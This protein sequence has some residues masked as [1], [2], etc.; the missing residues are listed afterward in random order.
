MIARPFH[1]SVLSASNDDQSENSNRNFDDITI[2]GDLPCGSKPGNLYTVN[3]GD[4][5]LESM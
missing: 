1:H 2:V 5:F 4:Y 3:S